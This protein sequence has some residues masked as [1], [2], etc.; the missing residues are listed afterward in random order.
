M[1][2]K[3]VD[4]FI[5]DWAYSHAMLYTYR[6]SHRKDSTPTDHSPGRFRKKRPNT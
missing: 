5:Q 6:V 4:Q 3:V 2:F 1:F